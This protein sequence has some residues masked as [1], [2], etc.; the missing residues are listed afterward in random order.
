MTITLPREQQEW[1][2]AQVEAGVCG[3]IDEALANIVAQRMLFEQL[4]QAEQRF[5]KL[6]HLE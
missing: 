5:D 3:S 6:Q 2:E 1:L 4:V